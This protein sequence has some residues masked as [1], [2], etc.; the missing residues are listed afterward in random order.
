MSEVNSKAKE[1][2]LAMLKEQLGHND[3]PT[4]GEKI[5]AQDRAINRVSVYIDMSNKESDSDLREFWK[6]VRQ[7]LIN[8]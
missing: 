1:K 8:L 7:E 4:F 2:A 5:E 3:D 6:N